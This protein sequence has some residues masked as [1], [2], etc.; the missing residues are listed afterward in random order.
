[1]PIFRGF[2]FVDNALQLAPGSRGIWLMIM[3]RV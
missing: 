2:F 1:L 3:S